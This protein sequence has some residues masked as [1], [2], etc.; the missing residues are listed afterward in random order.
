VNK[1]SVKLKNSALLAN[2]ELKIPKTFCLTQSWLKICR[3]SIQCMYFSSQSW[4]SSSF[5]IFQ[6]MWKPCRYNT[7]I[8]KFMLLV[9]QT[10]EEVYRGVKHTQII[11]KHSAEANLEVRQT[12]A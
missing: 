7:F 2:L 6:I 4:I 12:T 3:I 5:F 11:L 10:I 9:K 1:P 8:F